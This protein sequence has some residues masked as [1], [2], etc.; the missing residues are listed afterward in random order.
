[1]QKLLARYL[2]DYNPRW[3]GPHQAPVFKGDLGEG[4]GSKPRSIEEVVLMDC[5]CESC[6]RI[7]EQD[8][9]GSWSTLM[10][11]AAVLAVVVFLMGR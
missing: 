9:P 10:V 2:A 7:M 5:N 8:S 4:L 1:M 11:V 3:A 6:R